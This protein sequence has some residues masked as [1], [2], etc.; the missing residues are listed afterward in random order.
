MDT[1]VATMVAP[2]TLAGFQASGLWLRSTSRVRA[3]SS[4]FC[5]WHRASSCGRP[6]RR[7]Y[8]WREPFEARGVARRM[9]DVTTYSTTRL[10]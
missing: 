7:R 2:Y 8:R 3:P 5:S 1:R 6:V 4:T 10:R 9:P